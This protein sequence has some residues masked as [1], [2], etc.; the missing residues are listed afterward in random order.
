M[1]AVA[2]FLSIHVLI[3]NI[4][5]FCLLVASLS[6]STI[7]LSKWQKQKII[8]EFVDL[9]I[10]TGG[11]KHSIVL[12]TTVKQKTLVETEL[13]CL[14]LIENICEFYGNLLCVDGEGNWRVMTKIE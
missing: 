6:S 12:L 8:C 13:S 10:S 7:L 2:I 5:P 14:L 9:A 4:L 3:S 1:A 11:C